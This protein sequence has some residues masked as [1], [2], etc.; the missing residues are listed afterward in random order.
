MSRRPAKVDGKVLPGVR[1]N[2]GIAA[3]YRRKLDALILEMAR[4][5]A[6]WIKAQ[7]RANPPRMAMDA[8][9]SADLAKLMRRLGSKWEKRYAEMGPKLALHFARAVRNQSERDL[10]RIMREAGF[11]VNFTMST[12]LRDIMKAEITENVA[13]IKSIHEQY[14]TQVEGLVM[15]S[16]SEG[17][18]LKG[19]ADDLQSRYG[20]TRRRAEF[21][22]LDQNNKA[23]SAIQRERQ[24]SVGITK[25]IWM[26]SHAGK[27]PRPTHLAND[28]NE[29][30]LAEGWHD[31]DPKVNRRIW[32]GQLIRCRCTWK[33]VV[34]GFS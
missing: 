33:P 6:Y 19:L 24:T 32:P 17:R 26:H 11:S 3:S 9:S 29:F 20:I 22:A 31:P 25:A 15:R 13:L 30:D 27:E 14:H 5:Y 21:I 12:S 23:T 1:P 8:V 34:K 10:K 4:S 7:Y 18:D 2:A 28:R 16:V